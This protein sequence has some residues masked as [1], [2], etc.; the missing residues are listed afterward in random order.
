MRQTK[1]QNKST[2]NDPKTEMFCSDAT[3][4][5]HVL[6][7]KTHIKRWE[8]C[9]FSPLTVARCLLL[10]LTEVG[11]CSDTKNMLCAE[12]SMMPRNGATKTNHET[13]KENERKRQDE[14]IHL[15]H[16]FGG[17]VLLLFAMGG[18]R[19]WLKNMLYTEKS[20]LAWKG[21]SK[22]WAWK[23]TGIWQKNWLN[24]QHN[25]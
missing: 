21:C 18:L 20:A 9:L 2:Q 22:N 1:N 5:E 7:Q 17:C 14:H 15:P 12:L 4:N 8:E 16:F 19:L 23:W 10:L 25:N 13:P 3:K 24:S 6:D 11:W